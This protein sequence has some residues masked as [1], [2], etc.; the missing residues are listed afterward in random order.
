QDAVLHRGE[1]ALTIPG[2][3]AL[4][5]CRDDAQRQVQPRTAITYL[6]TGHQRRPIIEAGGR[7]GAAGTL[8]NVF[9]YL[10]ILVGPRAE[11][12]HRG[13]NHPGSEL[14]DA[15]PR[16]SHAIQRAGGEVLD[17]HVA[18]FHQL[19]EDLLARRALG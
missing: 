10:A 16:E 8:R 13:D 17:Q 15:L 1:Y 2:G 18:G 12:L 6:R 11:A 19:L 14:L 7:C 3:L 5:E 4:I 9:V